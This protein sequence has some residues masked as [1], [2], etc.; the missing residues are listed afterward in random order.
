MVKNYSVPFVKGFLFLDLDLDNPACV[1][2]P[3]VRIG[4]V[5]KVP[6]TKEE[7]AEFVSK[8]PVLGKLSEMVSG[9]CAPDVFDEYFEENNI[10]EIKNAIIYMWA[11]YAIDDVIGF[12]CMFEC[13]YE[14][15][16]RNKRNPQ[17]LTSEE[18]F[19]IVIA[20][21]HVACRFSTFCESINNVVNRYGCIKNE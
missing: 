15:A 5:E 9:Y 11:R 10:E 4:Y 14:R 3:F 6:E 19:E 20:L 8:N 7:Y 16:K 2:D 18:C 21:Q 12:T 1:I 17:K 13:D